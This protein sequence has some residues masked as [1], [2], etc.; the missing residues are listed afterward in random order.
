MY[1]HVLCHQSAFPKG[2]SFPTYLCLVREMPALQVSIHH[3]PTAVSTT[4]LTPSPS[5]YHS[6]QS[7]GKEDAVRGASSARTSSKSVRLAE[8]SVSRFTT[9]RRR[10]ARPTRRLV[11]L[12]IP[13]RTHRSLAERE[14]DLQ[15]EGRYS[16]NIEELLMVKTLITTSRKQPPT[17][18]H[19]LDDL[20][21]LN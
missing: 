8:E 5:I 19:A 4:C 6:Y 12:G 3:L 2:Y 11:F 17:A 15:L 21:K 9:M 1:N 7:Q 16:T 10:R 18:S 20:G 14:D 13:T